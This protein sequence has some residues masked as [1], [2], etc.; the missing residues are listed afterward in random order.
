MENIIKTLEMDK[1]LLEISKYAVSEK[2]KDKILNISFFNDIKFINVLLHEKLEAIKIINQVSN[3]TP[4]TN[5]DCDNILLSLKKG[6]VLNQLELYTL[7]KLFRSIINAKRVGL[8]SSKIID[9]KYLKKYFFDLTNTDDDLSYVLSIVN[10]DLE[11]LD[12]ASL[13]LKRIRSKITNLKSII[14]DK[15]DSLKKKYKDYLSDEVISYKNETYCLV[16]NK[17]FKKKVNGTVISIS[18]SGESFYVEP[19]EINQIKE[20]INLLKREEEQEINIILAKASIYLSE[21]VDS[22][23]ESLEIIYNLDF[24]FS[25]SNYLNKINANLPRINNNQETAIYDAK[26]PLIQGKVTPITINF[27]KTKKV[28]LITGPNTGGKTASLKTVGLFSLMVKAGL[29]VPCKENSNI[30]IFDN[31]YA[32]IGDE[33]SLVQSLS[34]FSSHLKKI[35]EITEKVTS[36]DLVLLDELG[37]GTDPNEGEALAQAIIEYLIKKGCISIITTHYSKLKSFA[38]EN[39]NINLASVAF[40]KNTLSPLYT[41]NMGVGGS[42]HALLIAKRLGLNSKIL[43]EANDI[44]KGK[45][46]ENIDFINKLNEEKEIVLNLKNE[47]SLLNEE[48]KNKIKEYEEKIIFI[49]N[50]K[51]KQIHEVKKQNSKIWDKK[52]NELE[53]LILELKNKEYITKE[54]LKNIS[55]K[56]DKPEFVNK[57]NYE[58]K[59]GDYVYI[60]NYSKNGIIL[61]IR[62]NKYLVDLGPFNLEFKK[63]DLRLSHTKP[64]INVISKNNYDKDNKDNFILN[65]TY[66]NVL[67]LRGKKYIEVEELIDKAIDDLLLANLNELKIIHGYGTGSVKKAVDSYIKKSKLIKS[68]RPGG[69]HEGMLGV[70]IV[71]LS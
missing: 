32:D 3:I 17:S 34:T 19:F 39:E 5:Y 48:L 24:I 29:L 38:Y 13:N 2:I 46:T 43:E 22:Y 7:T 23:L 56:I 31:I 53:E 71:K 16:V 58:F 62:N 54:E 61:K 52:L 68:H 51:D 26:H 35:I 33:Q 28:T 12:T 21:K 4:E 10:E 42:S 44:I 15:M 40:D 37:S 27:D 55:G 9:L 25:C 70:T 11:I 63:E 8:L 14:M 47:N 30:N 57:I 49:E 65:K 18:S 60:P 66:S 20:S 50:E 67:D 6:R 1:V 69:E 64:E 41:L 45:K 59:I 36:N